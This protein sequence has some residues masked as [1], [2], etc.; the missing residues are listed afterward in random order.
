MAARIERAVQV[1]DGVWGVILFC[2][3]KIDWRGR[4]D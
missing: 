3:G 1:D 4:E 2:F